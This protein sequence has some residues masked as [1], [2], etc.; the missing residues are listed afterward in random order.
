MVT[1]C[2]AADVDMLI[3]GVVRHDVDEG[4]GCVVDMQEFAPDGAAAPDHQLSVSR[5]FGL[6]SLADQAPG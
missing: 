6:V 3:L 1:S 2:A 4:V 5:D